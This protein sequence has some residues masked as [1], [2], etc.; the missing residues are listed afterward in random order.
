VLRELRAGADVL[1]LL[2]AEPGA[3]TAALLPRTLEGLYGLVYGLLGAATSDAAMA[4]A[5]AIVGQLGDIRA[6]QPLPLREVRTLA[7]ELLAQRALA[8]GLERAML[9]SPVYRAHM[10]EL[11][12]A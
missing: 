1:A 11:R 10:Q 2:S 12:G 6:S 8:T 7:V 5:L 9:D 4:R 3:A